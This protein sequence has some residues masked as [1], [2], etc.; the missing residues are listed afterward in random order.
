MSNDKRPITAEDLYQFQLVSSPRISPDRSQIIFSV[1]R[2]DEKKQKKYSNLWL[3][4]TDGSQPARQFT[5]GDQSDS[6]PR[7]SPDGRTIAFHSNRQDEKQ[8]Q[9]YLIPFFGGEARP[10]TDLKGKIGS[11]EWSPDGSQF[12]CQFRQKDEEA[13]EREEDEQKKKLGVVARHITRPEY[14]FDGVG[15]LPQNRWHLWRIDAKTGEATQLTEGDQYDETNPRWSPDGQTILFFSNRSEQPDFDWHLMDMWTIPAEGGEMTRLE[16]PVGLKHSAAFSPDGQ[17]IAFHC[18]EGKGTPWKQTNLWLLPADG[19]EAAR[20][21]TAVYDIELGS[22]TLTDTGDRAGQPPVWLPDGSRLYFQVTRHGRTQL[23]SLK[24]DGDDL[25]L[26]IDDGVV[27]SFSLDDAGERLAYAYTTYTDPGQVWVRHMADGSAQRLT[28]FNDDWLAEIDLGN[29]EEVWYKGADGNDLQGWLVKP[30]D[31][32]DSKQYPAI[33]EIH[34][35]PWLQYGRAFMHEFYYLAAQGYVVAFTNP[36]GGQGYGEAHAKA[37]DK[38]WGEA[39]YADMMAWADYVEALPYVDAARMGVTG[40]SYGGYMTTWIIGHTDRFKAAVAQRVVSNTISFWASS[41]VG[42]FFQDVWSGKPPW[43]DLEG[44]WNQSPIK[45][46]HNAK[47][48]TLVMH[49]EQDLRCDQEQGEQV[50]RTLQWLGVESELVLFPEESH[51]LSRNGR[52]D[53]RIARLEHMKRW[54]DK[55]L[56]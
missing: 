23:C 8:T 24:P 55:Y 29:V 19:S 11:F 17:W 27:D 3:V 53:R 6:S 14:K 39:D 43:E 30:P 56:T 32:D 31:F 5:Y 47:T 40:G 4:P 33:I 10:L 41:D 46:I 49:S 50:F 45:Y 36:R 54:F 44:Y 34:G 42:Y 16:T 35:G 12:I 13:I 21:L 22:G 28:D 48:P 9:L 2:V 26:E 1:Q 37:I 18:R 51:G 7:W 52:T 38:H 25:R 15:Y 20:N